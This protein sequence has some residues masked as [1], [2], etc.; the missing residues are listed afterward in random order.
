MPDKL[1]S[2]APEVKNNDRARCAIEVIIF[3]KA[4]DTSYKCSVVSTLAPYMLLKYAPYYCP[5]TSKSLLWPL[6]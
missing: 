1:P 6:K 2:L 5:I 3:E 4:E